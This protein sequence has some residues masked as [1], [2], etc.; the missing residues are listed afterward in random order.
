MAS[1][2]VIWSGSALFS[3]QDTVKPVYNS[4][5]QKG[6]K[7]FFKTN[8]QKYCRMLQGE[9]LHYFRPSFKLP[10]FIKFFVVTI[11]EWLFYTGFTVYLSSARQGLIGSLHS[12]KL[13]GVAEHMDVSS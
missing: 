7:L 12:V 13:V 8:Y 11:F 2:Q 6:R 5:S 3:K 9:L 1:N 10:F 4:H